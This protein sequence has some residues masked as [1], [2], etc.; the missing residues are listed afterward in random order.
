[1]APVFK[2]MPMTMVSKRNESS[3]GFFTEFEPMDR[4]VVTRRGGKN[5]NRGCGGGNTS[6]FTVTFEHS[7]TV[8]GE[9][10]MKSCQDRNCPFHDHF[11]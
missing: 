2:N 10:G 5:L 11:V 3:R 1:M 4:S 8:G 6:T 9:C 7:E